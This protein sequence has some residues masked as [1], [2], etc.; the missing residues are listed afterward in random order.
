MSRKAPFISRKYALGDWGKAKYEDN[1]NF[2]ENTEEWEHESD[3]AL[4]L[5]AEMLGELL[6]W[7]SD[8][9]M[10]GKGYKECIARKTIAMIWCM[11]PDLFNNR[12]LREISRQGGVMLTPASLS[13]HVTFFTDKFGRFHTGTKSEEA[14]ENYRKSAK[15]IHAR[16]RK[17]NE[18]N[19]SND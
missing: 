10:K 15:K 9:N 13:K 12:S 8:G 16:K 7:L 3:K 4:Y 5:L 18:S 1:F 17:E 19:R 2:D 6:V 14:K 11:R